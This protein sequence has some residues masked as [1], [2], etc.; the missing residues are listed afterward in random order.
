MARDIMK[1]YTTQ[2]LV[3]LPA[4]VRLELSKPQAQAREYA[5]LRLGKTGH[6]YLTTAPVQFKA[7][8][9]IGCEN[10]VP[11]ALAAL[12]EAAPVKKDVPSTP[13]PTPTE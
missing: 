7:G 5:L 13:A 3:T 10:D 8:E 12:V 1:K 11:K 6:V 2:S 9:V 4:G